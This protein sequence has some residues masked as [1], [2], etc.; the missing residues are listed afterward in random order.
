MSSLIKKQSSLISF[1]LI[2]ALYCQS[3]EIFDNRNV[4]FPSFSQLMRKFLT[5]G[6]LL[7]LLCAKAQKW[8][9]NVLSKHS[10]AFTALENVSVKHW[11]W[12]VRWKWPKKI[13]DKNGQQFPRNNLKINGGDISFLPFVYIQTKFLILERHP[14]VYILAFHLRA[15]VILK[16]EQSCLERFILLFFTFLVFVEMAQEK[17]HQTNLYFCLSVL[18]NTRPV[19]T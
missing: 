2:S 12:K 6:N 7:S 10:K 18:F 4:I 17:A 5:S 14:S 8:A 11:V 3:F 19:G 13:Y 9:F 16:I 15:D 1:R